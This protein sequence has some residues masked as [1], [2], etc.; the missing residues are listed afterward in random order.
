ML[1]IAAGCAF[2]GVQRLDLQPRLHPH[3]TE[4]HQDRGIGVGSRGDAASEGG[5]VHHVPLLRL[6]GDFHQ[7]LDIGGIGALQ[8]RRGSERLAGQRGL[9]ELL[10]GSAQPVV[11]AA[12]PRRLLHGQAKRL[13]RPARLSSA[14]VGGRQLRRRIVN[15]LPQRHHRL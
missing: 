12:I 5:G 15:R 4:G 3:E 14:L 13:N 10:V 9:A 2:E 1:I 8:P 7:R 6:A 11:K